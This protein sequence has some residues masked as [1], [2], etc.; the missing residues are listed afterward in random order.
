MLHVILISNPPQ[1]HFYILCH[2]TDRYAQ[3]SFYKEDILYKTYSAIMR[4]HIR[5]IC[6]GFV[7][8]LAGEAFKVQPIIRLRLAFLRGSMHSIQ[9][10]VTIVCIDNR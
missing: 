8:C 1:T 9:V 7:V 3:A 4:S 5:G 10:H 2:T 6:F